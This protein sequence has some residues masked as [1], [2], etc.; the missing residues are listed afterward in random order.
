MSKCDLKNIFGDLSESLPFD[1]RGEGLTFTSENLPVPPA[2]I[3]T[4]N[5]YLT[6]STHIYHPSFRI[7]S[8]GFNAHKETY[9]HLGLLILSALFHPQIPKIFV[10]LNHAESDISNFVIECYRSELD[11]LSGG[12]HKKP[13]A[14]Q[15]YPALTSKHPFDN[16]I[17]PQNLP[18]FALTNLEDFVNS[19]DD[20]NNRD[21]VKIFGSDKGGVC[22]DEGMVLFAELL[23]NI[24]LP[25]NEQDEYALE[26]E[27][28]FRGVGINSAEVT[29]LL[30]GHIFWFDEHWQ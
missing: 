6:K 11:R 29:L 15:Y 26:G 27:N 25:Q 5:L 10:K 24:A 12:Y 14:F 19:E 7:D 9:R 2:Q 18:C 21:T 4:P 13:F 28:G 1:P 3:E 20:W 30:P 23:L 16:C 22:T 8:I 17:E